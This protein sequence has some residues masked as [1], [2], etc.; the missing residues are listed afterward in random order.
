MGSIRAIRTDD[1]EMA[2]RAA[3]Y[4]QKISGT[5]RRSAMAASSS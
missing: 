2:I 4:C 3:P 1:P 5:N